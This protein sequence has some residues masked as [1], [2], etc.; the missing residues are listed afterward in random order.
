MLASLSLAAPR[1]RGSTSLRPEN[2]RANTQLFTDVANKASSRLLFADVSQEAWGPNPHFLKPDH[3][4][5]GANH[6]ATPYFPDLD[7][8]GILDFFYHNHFRSN[9]HHEWDVGLGCTTEGG[10]PCFESIRAD[11]ILTVTEDPAIYADVPVNCEDPQSPHCFVKDGPFPVDAHGVAFVDIDKDGLLDMYISTGADHG[12]QSGPVYDSFLAWG[13][14]PVAVDQKS[15]GKLKQVAH[16]RGGRDAARKANMHNPDAS[17]RLAYFVDFDSDGTLDLAFANQVRESADWIERDG[18]GESAPAGVGLA[19]KNQ[20]NRTF[21]PLMGFAEYARTMLLTDADGDGHANELVVQR[22]E[23]L[24]RSFRPDGPHNPTKT[25]EFCAARPCATTAV[26][27]YDHATHTLKLLNPSDSTQPATATEAAED[28]EDEEDDDEEEEE[29]EEKV[30]LAANA[31]STDDDATVG[32]DTADEDADAEE[33]E[34]ADEDAANSTGADSDKYLARRALRKLR[35]GQWNL[36]SAAEQ[37]QGRV[38]WRSRPSTPAAAAV[39]LL[40]KSS[41]AAAAASHHSSK[42]SSARSSKHSSKHHKTSP[43]LSNGK[44]EQQG[45]K[46]ATSSSS[47]PLLLLPECREECAAAKT[48]NEWYA[49]CKT[50]ACAACSQCPQNQKRC[51]AWCAKSP[52]KW[53]NKCLQ[54]DCAGC[55]MCFGCQEWCTRNPTG[56]DVKCGD[57]GCAGCDQCGDDRETRKVVEEKKKRSKWPGHEQ[58][59]CQLWCGRYAQISWKRKCPDPRCSECVSCKKYEGCDTLAGCTRR[60]KT[61]LNFGVANESHCLGEAAWSSQ[62]GDFDADGIA[63][64]A[65]LYMDRIDLYYSSQRAR[66]ELPTGTPSEMLTWELGDTVDSDGGD[67]ATSTGDGEGQQGGEEDAT[68]GDADQSLEGETPQECVPIGCTGT[69][70]VN[71]SGGGGHFQ[72]TWPYHC[73]E[74]DDGSVGYKC[75]CSAAVLS[76]AS[77]GAHHQLNRSSRATSMVATTKTTAL[78]HSMRKVAAKKKTTHEHE[79]EHDEGAQ[80]GEGEEEAPGGHGKHEHEPSLT[81]SV[82]RIAKAASRRIKEAVLLS[83][84]TAQGVE[85]D[86]PCTGN[87]MRVADFNLDGAQDL[88]VVCR[89]PGRSRLYMGNPD[90]NLMGGGG[91]KEEQSNASSGTSAATAAASAAAAAPKWALLDPLSLGALAIS[92]LAGRKV[93]ADNES[94]TVYDRDL[95][96]LEAAKRYRKKASNWTETKAAVWHKLNSSGAVAANGTDGGAAKDH[97][98]GGNKAV[99]RARKLKREAKKKAKEDSQSQREERIRDVQMQGLLK[100]GKEAG[101]AWG[102]LEDGTIPVSLLQLV[103]GGG[104]WRR[105]N[106]GAGRNASDRYAGRRVQQ[107]RRP[108]LKGAEALVAPMSPHE[109]LQDEAENQARYELLGHEGDEEQACGSKTICAWVAK[110]GCDNDD[111]TDRWRCCCGDRVPKAKW[112]GGGSDSNDPIENFGVSVVD[113]NNDGYIDVSL[114]YKAGGK[115]L[116]MQN[117]FGDLLAEADKPAHRFLALRLVGTRSNTAAVGATVLLEADGFGPNGDQTLLQMREVNS[118]SHEN[119][120]WGTRDERIIFGLGPRGR[121]T[122]LAVRWP[123]RAGHSRTQLVP[124]VEKWVNSMTD[125][126]VVHE[127]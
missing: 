74:P 33:D 72:E 124:D 95:A 78:K 40:A 16:F 58:G 104:R 84:G 125:L 65:V 113:W 56:W 24:P 119:D 85:Q 37:T 10:T 54:G 120:W 61:K 60:A 97:G 114:G 75:C 4:G 110:W 64:L 69:L 12:T 42:Q 6:Q 32:A 111:G 23:C 102:E 2:M 123:G 35:L 29:E 45:Q 51:Q 106:A 30:E 27:K 11:Q 127:A 22:R 88:L 86:Q 103:P 43:T 26:Y 59:E 91:A 21:A 1:P 55:G 52:M 81:P 96:K 3:V 14:Q 90:R 48:G 67:N 109:Y 19:L 28:E 70:A 82:A 44:G 66:G 118:A 5:Q 117:Q 20:G 63:D 116:L 17:G 121:P 99:W 112:G 62:A 76:A 18:A 39:S 108:S 50:E 100:A 92:D 47:K 9:L 38:V 34:D 94:W 98:W 46:A 13:D 93:A 49:A 107:R 101:G 68:D 115:Q 53:S 73:D 87:G 15:A 36:S 31:T 41:N 7:G 79:H 83:G 105:A 80:Q 25:A 89:E 71:E 77:G 57:S 8:D 122:K 126:L